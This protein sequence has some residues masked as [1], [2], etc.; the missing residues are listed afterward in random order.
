MTQN[1]TAEP[2]EF[3][4]LRYMTRFSCIGPKCE[5]TCCGGWGIPVKKSTYQLIKKGMDNSKAER[6]R[7]RQALSRN[8]PTDGKP[9]DDAAY[10]RITMREDNDH[11]HLMTDEGWCSVQSEIGEHAVP[12]VCMVYPR[13]QGQFGQRLETSGYISCPEAARLML[14]AEDSCVV[15]SVG[16]PMTDRRVLVQTSSPRAKKPYHREVDSI[17][18][19]MLRLLELPG[20]SLQSR[21]FL[22]CLFAERITPFFHE[23]TTEP[24]DKELAREITRLANAAER[25]AAIRFIDSQE[26]QQ[27]FSV[28]VVAQVLSAVGSGNSGKAGKFR[29]LVQ[30]AF[31]GYLARTGQSLPAEPGSDWQPD[32]QSIVSEYTRTIRS[33]EL[34]GGETLDRMFGNF[35]KY[36]VYSHWYTKS[37][38]LVEYT[39]RMLLETALVR[40][41]IAGHPDLYELVTSNQKLHGEDATEWPATIRAEFTAQLERTA[42][43][44]FYLT[45]RSYEHGVTVMSEIGEALKKKELQTLAGSVYLLKF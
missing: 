18:E 12:D 23:D 42:V 24:V 14:L 29:D 35:A 17:R 9:V 21:L 4:T 36:F 6:S 43:E 11:C 34:A 32:I 41:L 5:D 33:L 1:R 31:D 40:F 44:C 28:L 19:V 38:N 13:M 3:R 27:A 7:F 45:A 20:A 2:N 37:P 22:T 15:E 8:R 16:A 26:P 25:N 30:S 10:A 39:Q